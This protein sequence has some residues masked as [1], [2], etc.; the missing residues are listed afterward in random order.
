MT[1]AEASIISR[2]EPVNL[3]FKQVLYEPGKAIRHIY[4]PSDCLIAR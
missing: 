1:C 2:L 3:E 4:F